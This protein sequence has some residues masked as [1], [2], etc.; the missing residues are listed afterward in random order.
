MANDRLG[1][2]GVWLPHPMA[3]P[4]GVRELEQL[5]YGAI[6][7]GS[8]PAADWDGYEALLSASESITIGTSIVNVWAS[9]AEESARTFHRLEDRYPGR[10]LL[11]IGAGHRE[12]ND[13]YTKPFDAL[14]NYLDELDEAGVPK[15]RRALAALGPKVAELARDRTAG[16]LPYLTTPDHTAA[17]RTLLG[18]D[19]LIA[20]EHK[21]VLDADPERARTIGRDYTRFYLTL[22]NYANNLRR[23]GFG[24]EELEGPGSDRLVD[25]LI[26][27]GTPDRI[28]DAATAH[29]RAGGDHVALQVVGGDHLQ[30][31]RTLAPLLTAHAN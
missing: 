16:A 30:A 10:F 12:Q 24:P 8:S 13:G 6:W 1:K 11:G 28:L 20:T 23:S 17:L 18:P 7:L 26:L 27:H 14:V 29:L 19:T 25:A 2:F 9:P 4:D 22:S 31:L 21:I 5:G 3:T 15:E